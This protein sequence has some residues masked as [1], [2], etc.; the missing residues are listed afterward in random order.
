[1]PSV[2]CS[3]AP[4]GAGS[5]ARNDVLAGDEIEPQAQ[6][7]ETTEVEDQGQHGA[8]HPAQGAIGVRDLGPRDQ[9]EGNAEDCQP[10]AGRA[11]R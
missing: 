7:G 5:L 1:M 4:R 9:R 2:P 10:E 6:L 8:R 11:E 3:M